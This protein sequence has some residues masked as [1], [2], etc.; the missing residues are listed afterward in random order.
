M[1]VRV[2][3]VQEVQEVQEATVAVVIAEVEVAARKI[4]K[5]SPLRVEANQ[6]LPRQ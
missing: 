5:T 1:I 3:V 4:I 2:A 6:L